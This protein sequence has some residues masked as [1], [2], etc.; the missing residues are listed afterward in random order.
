MKKLSWFVLILFLLTGASGCS[1]NHRKTQEKTQRMLSYINNKYTEDHFEYAGITGGHLGSNTTKIIV[2]SEKLPEKRICVIA[3]ETDD[4]EV[5]S[6]TYLHAKFAQ[7]TEAYL[8]DA[9]TG[10][11]GQDIY[12][13]FIP[14]DTAGMQSGSSRTTFEEY[15]ADPDTYIY[16]SAAV[17]GKA[18]DEEKEL[19]RIKDAFQNA[20]VIGHI[21]YMDTDEPIQ[22]TAKAQIEAKAYEKRLYIVKESVSEYAKAEW[23]AGQ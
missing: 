22:D 8:R 23:T 15:L 12:L 3:S 16:F 21:F 2:R 7:Q 1:T 4:G 11:Y 20:V 13:D 5:F 6:D 18:E 9:L 19:A 14:D 17:P 10:L